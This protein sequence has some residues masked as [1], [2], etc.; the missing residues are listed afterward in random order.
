MDDVA[1]DYFVHHP[2]SPTILNHAQISDLVPTLPT[3]EQVIPTLADAPTNKEN[4]AR[5]KTKGKISQSVRKPPTVVLAPKSTNIPP[6]KSGPSLPSSSR[7]SKGRI[8]ST[9]LNPAKHGA[10]EISSDSA[11]VV[12]AKSPTKKHS[13]VVAH[14]SSTVVI[15]N[16]NS[17]VDADGMVE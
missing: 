10:M 3:I 2:V 1:I 4:V 16:G 9:V 15:L 14:N 5:S 8:V 17:G 13:A 6:R 7:S 11:P 12:I